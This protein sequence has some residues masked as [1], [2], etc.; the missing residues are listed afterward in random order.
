MDNQ[1]G[2]NSTSQTHGWIALLLYGI[3]RIRIN[4]SR[5]ERQRKL[6]SHYGDGLGSDGLPFMGLTGKANNDLNRNPSLDII[7]AYP[8]PY[9]TSSSGI[10]SGH[11]RRR[12]W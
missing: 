12:L 8:N 11:A 7:A 9:I 4:T 2:L 1:Y 10:K 3:R 6:F 5:E